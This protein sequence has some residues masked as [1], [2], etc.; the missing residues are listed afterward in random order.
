VGVEEFLDRL[1][2]GG[3]SG[4]PIE[5][6]AGAPRVDLTRSA[7][8]P[9]TGRFPVPRQTMVECLVPKPVGGEGRALMHQ[10]FASPTSTPRRSRTA[11]MQVISGNP[12]GR[13]KPRTSSRSSPAVDLRPGDSSLMLARA[14][15]FGLINSQWSDPHQCMWLEGAS[16]GQPTLV[17]KILIIGWLRRRQLLL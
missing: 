16:V 4:K 3:D 2:T 7:A 9:R 8:R 1:R 14:A 12:R 10:P 6:P 5:I 11:L 15:L 13:M 17:Q